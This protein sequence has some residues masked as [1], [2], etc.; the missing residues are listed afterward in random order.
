MSREVIKGRDGFTTLGY[1]ETMSDGKQKTLAKDGFTTLGFY[2]PKRNET[3]D[4][5]GF[6]TIAH[7]NVL[8][9]LIYEKR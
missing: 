4:K 6:R 5:D 9:G 8:S 2:D 7:G 3:F 1:V